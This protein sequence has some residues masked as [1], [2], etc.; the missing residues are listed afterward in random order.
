ML[1]VWLG[2]AALADASLIPDYSFHNDK[3]E[4][5]WPIFG[6]TH[7]KSNYEVETDNLMDLSH[8]EM[9]HSRSFGGRGYFYKG[10][11]QLV[12]RGSEIHAN[13]WIP[14]VPHLNPVDAAGTLGTATTRMDHY[15]DMRWNAPSAMRLHTGF[16]PLGEFSNRA[17]GLREDVPGQFTSHILTPETATT[18][19]YFWSGNN[20][21]DLTAGVPP[22]E[23]KELLRTA[24]EVEDK[25]LLEVVQQNME[26]D[27]WKM[28]PAIL[29]TDAGGVRARRRLAK[30]IAEERKSR[31]EPRGMLGPDA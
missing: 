28:K 20:P 24:F 19:H 8:L 21:N 15:L 26:D 22:L 10:A 14:N 25:P 1:W 7:V 5:G 13:W 23:M 11:F 4:P 6:Y 16:I 17:E 18:T 29:P 2:Q 3:N 30:M 12:D 31:S 9:V 27:F